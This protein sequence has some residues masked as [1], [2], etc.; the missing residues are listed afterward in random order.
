MNERK[1]WEAVNRCMK[2]REISCSCGGPQYGTDHAPDCEWE[3][4]AIE[5]ENEIKE[6]IEDGELELDDIK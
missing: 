2:R 1:L 3:L 4:Q 5:I 6:L